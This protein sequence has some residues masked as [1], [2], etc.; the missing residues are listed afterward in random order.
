MSSCATPP[1]ARA[2]GY[3]LPPSGLK[4][5]EQTSDIHDQVSAVNLREPAGIPERGNL[6]D[7]ARQ[8]VES[9]SEC[10]RS[11]RAGC[12]EVIRLERLSH[13]VLAAE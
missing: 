8:K 5:T 2:V 12:R 3:L 13:H 6:V 10:A 4:Q 9:Q 1:T 7:Q 11:R